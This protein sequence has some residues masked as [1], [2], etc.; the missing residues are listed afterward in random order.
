MTKFLID[1]VSDTVCPWCYVGF[2]RLAR[3]I[4]IY[5]K[6][7][8]D[9]SFEIRWH[10]FYLNPNAPEVGVD[11]QKVYEAK[12]GRD[13][14]AMMQRRLAII[15]AQEGIAFAFG[16]KTGNTRKSH[17]LMQLAGEKGV[18]N[19]VVEQLFISYFE[20]EQDI[21]DDDVLKEA[22]ISGGLVAE[23]VDAYLQSDRGG[24]QVDR[25]VASAQARR[26]QGVPHFTINGTVEFG[27]A[28]EPDAFLQ[29]FQGYGGKT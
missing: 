14:T 6:T 20:S 3:A 18:Q 9:A 4:E 1:V 7:N 5:K 23:D 26:I 17:R 24:E 16:G 19:Q 21:T 22:A 29:A 10:P 8:Q 25:E 15:G 27:G 11:K 13:R 12:F 28:Q 2:K